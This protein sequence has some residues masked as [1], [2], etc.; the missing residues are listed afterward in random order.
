[1]DPR[2]K[3]IVMNLLND[4]DLMNQI[5]DS[6][7]EKFNQIIKTTYLSY[8][9]DIKGTVKYWQNSFLKSCAILPKCAHE[10]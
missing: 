10:H 5:N 9:S 3:T 6:C 1:M 8:I 7:Q 2:N 4:Q